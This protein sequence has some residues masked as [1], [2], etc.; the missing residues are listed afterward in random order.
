M[1]NACVILAVLAMR[2]LEPDLEFTLTI[3]WLKI[4]KLILSLY[5]ASWLILSIHMWI[6]LRYRNFALGVAVGVFGVFL[7]NYP[8]SFFPQLSKLSAFVPWLLVP[9]VKEI[10]IY[11]FYGF[12][13][14]AGIFIS[15]LACREVTRR[16]IL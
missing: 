2:Y 7:A 1:L 8:F 13:I 16:D 12:R 10:N 11:L 3:P 5:C 9:V 4:L 14:L 15:L 6:A